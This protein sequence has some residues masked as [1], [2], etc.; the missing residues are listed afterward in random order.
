MNEGLP[1]V[2][3]EEEDALVP[4][5][6]ARQ[7]TLQALRWIGFETGTQAEALADELG[8]LSDFV[9]LTDEDIKNMI[10]DGVT[11][12]GTRTKVRFPTKP[13]KRLVSIIEW[14]KDRIKLNEPVSL[15]NSGIETKDEFIN[16]IKLAY[17]RKTIRELE[18][19]TL[20]AQLKVASPGKLK[21]EKSW[22]DWVTGLETTLT[23][24]RGVTEVPLVYV[25]RR[26]KS[27]PD[28]EV[29]ASFDEECVAKTPLSG[30]A[31][32]AD[33]RS[34]HLIIQP[35]VTGEN[36]AQ[37]IECVKDKNSGREDF[38]KLQAHYQGE[39]NA[40]RRI[41]IA[42]TLWST[43][44][45]KNER[46]FP[47]STFL[48][49]AQ[50]MMNIYSQNKEPKPMAAQVRWLLDQIQDPTLT[51]TI[52]GLKVDISK[53]PE[54]LIWTFTRCANHIQ[55][56]IRQK[57]ENV[58]TVS[59]V[60]AKT[61]SGRNG[62]YKDGEIFTGKYSFEEWKAL[63]SEDR[64]AV[65]KARNGN[66][67]GGGNGGG[68]GG[69]QNNNKKVKALTR[70]VKRQKKQIASLKKRG[71][72]DSDSSGDESEK[73]EPMNDAGNSF[74]GRAGKKNSKKKKTE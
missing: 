4:E 21:D 40:S 60:N 22:E 70:K 20:E 46:A 2:D 12:G 66:K 57:T 24:I 17:S 23:L 29:Y 28:G 65:L 36:A 55:S 37:W 3:E 56:Q 67:K 25:I 45:Y 72:P 71:A 6:I 34:V 8:N 27:P 18:K 50:F 62:I 54:H 39:G 42:E 74:G 16:A 47:F 69:A 53:D 68:G 26:D 33:A 48:S 32:E 41:H 9:T 52:A 43:L 14:A 11:F 73:E 38:L 58:K 63:S 19:D 35:L 49:K 10:K 59:G 30:P 15:A 51:A 13:R 7:E 64:S 5:D 61:G 44:H 1:D 31:F